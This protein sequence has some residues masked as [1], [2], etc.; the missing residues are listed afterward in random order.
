MSYLPMQRYKDHEVYHKSDLVIIAKAKMII[1]KK[2][3]I[4]DTYSDVVFYAVFEIEHT[5]K[6]RS[7]NKEILMYVGNT[8]SAKHKYFTKEIYENMVYSDSHTHNSQSR[9]H[10]IPRQSYLL[11]LTTQGNEYTPSNFWDSILRIL[12]DD[13]N[14]I[15]FM[16][17]HEHT[18]QIKPLKEYEKNRNIRLNLLNT[19]YDP[20][21]KKLPKEY[22]EID[23]F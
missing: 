10:V 12:K 4:N 6:G 18:T 2:E 20:N 16:P 5:L 19:R 23:I 13:D 8:G 17:G 15:Y 11:E 1:K 3:K 22:G 21:I 14:K 7:Q 9:Y